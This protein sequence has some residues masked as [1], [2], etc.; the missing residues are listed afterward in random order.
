LDE[1]QKE[2]SHL[3][4]GDVS[5]VRYSDLESCHEVVSVHQNVDI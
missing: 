2:L 1:V 4:L 5:L 3:D